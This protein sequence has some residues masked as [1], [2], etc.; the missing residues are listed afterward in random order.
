MAGLGDLDDATVSALRASTEIES[1]FAQ[2]AAAGVVEEVMRDI[3]AEVTG[4]AVITESRTLSGGEAD[5]LDIASDDGDV[6]VSVPFA[7]I[8][9]LV[10]S[11][12]LTVTPVTDIETFAASVPSPRVTAAAPAPAPTDGQTGATGSPSEPQP[13][14]GLGLIAIAS[15]V[16]MVEVF[17]IQL[18]DEAGELITEFEEELELEFHVDPATTN[19]DTIAVF[20]FDIELG[21]WVQV[22]ATVAADGT[23]VATTTRL[24]TWAVV[25][26]PSLQWLLRRGWNAVTFTGPSGYAVSDVAAKVS[27]M[28]EMLRFNPVT[29]RFDNYRPG[30]AGNTLE[31]L[32][33]RDALFVRVDGDTDWILTDMIPD[34]DGERTVMLHPG[35]NAI[36][37]TGP[38]QQPLAELVQSVADR[39]RIIWRLDNV[40]Q[41]WSSYILGAPDV[42][43][44]FTTV[45]RLDTIVI[46]FSNGPGMQLT[47]PER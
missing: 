9:E 46:R 1:I 28:I 6:A 12:T 5:V 25:E 34:P 35:I 16:R 24:S 3:V 7:A 22:P 23:I 42:V 20:R 40:T 15:S 31:R 8:P 44:D 10:Q 29:Q 27:A 17:S 30:F 13:Q 19:L 21:E 18:A 37:Y 26:V 11:V 14:S 47:L 32:N 33:Q 2:L 45:D 4:E 43:N 38:D 41:R 36:G 39:V